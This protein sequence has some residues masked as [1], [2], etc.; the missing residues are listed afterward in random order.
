M[1]PPIAHLPTHHQFLWLD[2]SASQFLQ[3]Y[4]PSPQPIPFKWDQVPSLAHFPVMTQA[5]SE[6]DTR[7]PK[8]HFKLF[9]LS[10]P[11]FQG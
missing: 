1:Q 2:P 6:A 4:P 10:W 9:N 5:M 11:E 3:L 7:K 8:E